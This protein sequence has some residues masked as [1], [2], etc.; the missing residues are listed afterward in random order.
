MRI[1]VQIGSKLMGRN[2][3][4]TR[5]TY[6]NGAAIRNTVPLRNGLRTNTYGAC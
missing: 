2:N 3:P 5:P 1:R 4:T 6:G